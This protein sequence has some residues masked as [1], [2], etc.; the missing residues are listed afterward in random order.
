MRRSTT[1]K[2]GSVVANAD[3]AWVDMVAYTPSAAPEIAVEQPVG[4]NLADGSALTAFQLMLDRGQ[5]LDWFS[6]TEVA[7]EAAIA[8]LFGY[9]AVVH[10]FTTADPFIKPAIFKDRNFLIGTILSVIV[11]ILL[12]GVIPVMTGA[13]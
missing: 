8:A 11:G 10:V 6:S 2:I 7:I 3:A 13:P 5:L 1:S 4:S 12:N 9:L